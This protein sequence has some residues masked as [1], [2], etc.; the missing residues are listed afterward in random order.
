MTD[1]IVIGAGPAGLTAAADLARRGARV[2]IVD[3][4]EDAGGVPR[5]SDHLGYGLRDLRRVM[6]G[7]AYARTLADQATRAGAALDLRATVTDLRPNGAGADVEITSPA[8][9]ETVSAVAV[10]L[11]TGCRERP[12]AARLVPGDRPSGI[13]TTGWLQRLVHLDHGS[14]GTRAVVVGAEHVSYSAVLT[15]AEAGCRTVAMVTDADAHESFSA[16]DAAAR[17]RYRFPLLT[18]TRVADIHGTDTVT[19]VT[20]AHDDGRLGHLDCDVVVFTG[21]WVPESDLAMRGHLTLDRGTRGPSVNTGLRTSAAGIFAAGNVLHPA[22][23]ADVCAIDGR[24]VA[25]YV[26]K[27]LAGDPWPDSTAPVITEAPLLWSAPD[28]VSPGGDV[29]LRM[30]TQVAVNRP[31]FTVTQGGRQLWSGRLPWIRPTRPFALP[32]RAT[33]DAVATEPLVVA[34]DS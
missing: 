11:A 15:L 23:T 34:L 6:T 31:R 27:W 21:D 13:Y 14:P 20:I 12:R 30:Q 2:R 29:P 5:Y 22:S 16:F 24:G 8:G 10:L 4:D 32:A 1:V 28:R 26:E 3:R 17:L 7:P 9:R 18:R 25:A 33:A 19:G